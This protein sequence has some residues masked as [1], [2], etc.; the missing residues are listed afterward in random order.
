MARSIHGLSKN[1]SNNVKYT[2]SAENCKLVEKLRIS[3][4][5]GTVI[6]KC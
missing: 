4:T 2:S 5:N 1:H 3:Y 6:Q